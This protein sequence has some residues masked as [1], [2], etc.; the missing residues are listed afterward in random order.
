MYKEHPNFVAMF[1][2]KY[3]AKR[4]PEFLYQAIEHYVKNKGK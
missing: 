3:Q 1:Q 4:L 2:P